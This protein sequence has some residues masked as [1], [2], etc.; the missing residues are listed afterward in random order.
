MAKIVGIADTN[1]TP[2]DSDKPIEGKTLYTTETMDPRRGQGETT[3]HF[4][5][6]TAKL[7]TLDFVPAPSQ[8][9]EVFYNRYGKV[10]KLKLVGD[11]NIITA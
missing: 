7:A 8:M 11:D 10:Q 5:L 6:T 2:K 1:F 4:F 3:D 9:V